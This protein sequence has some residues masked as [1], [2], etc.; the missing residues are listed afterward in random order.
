VAGGGWMARSAEGSGWQAEVPATAGP[1]KCE[2][3]TRARCRDT[4]ECPPIEIGMAGIGELGT[5][6]G[7]LLG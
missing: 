1:R 7:P 4:L 2:R 5:K 3:A 6:F